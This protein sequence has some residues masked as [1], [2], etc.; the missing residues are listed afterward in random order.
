MTQDV[1][2]GSLWRE[3]HG[4]MVDWRVLSVSDGIVQAC[5]KGAI[6]IRIKEA[7]WLSGWEPA[8]MSPFKTSPP[9]P[10]GE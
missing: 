2:V 10:S 1:K 9:T 6:P 4:G 8:E 7:Q 5:I 3:T